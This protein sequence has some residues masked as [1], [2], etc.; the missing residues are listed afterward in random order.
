MKVT[1][2]EVS[3]IFKYAIF[4]IPAT[5][6]LII[7]N[8]TDPINLP[9][10]LALSI[11]AFI[12][13]VLLVALR[14]YTQTR[15]YE[16]IEGKALVSLYF[17][18]G[19]FMIIAGL[20]NNGNYIRA[21]FGTNGRN[22]GLIYYLTAILVSLILLCVVIKEL[23]INYLYRVLSFTSIIFALYCLLQYLDLDPIAWNNPYSR[24]IGTLGNPNFSASALA[25]FAIFWFYMLISNYSK[26]VNF[27][28]FST[29]MGISLSF[30]SWSTESLQG[31][32]VLL[33]GVAFLAFIA[34]RERF[35][36]RAIPYLFFIGGGIS[37]LFVFLSFLGIG[38]L[39]AQLE[40]YTLKLRGYYAYFA[41]LAMLDSPWS[42]VGVDNYITAFRKFRTQEFIQ[43]Y[44]VALNANNA[45]STPAQV[46]AT[47][48]VIVFSLY[49][50][51]HLWILIR[52]LK[53]INSRNAS[54]S[55]L[56]GIALIWILVFS[57]SI[58]SIEIIGLG[59]MNWLLGAILLNSSHSLRV[60][61]LAS[62]KVT[63]KKRE[64]RA[65]PVWVG[66]LTIASFAIGILP[67]IGISIEDR[68]LLNITTIRVENDESR[69][70]VRENFNKLSNRTLLES[71]QVIQ[72]VN[73]LSQAGLNKEV[74]EILLRLHELNPRDPYPVDLLSSYYSNSN[75]L[76][77]EI[78]FYIKFIEL[79]PLNYQME[80]LL[81]DAY[82][83][84]GD[85]GLLAKS[86]ERI[87]ALA[88]ESQEFLDA[89][90]LLEKLKT[91]PS[92]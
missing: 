53:I 66:S 43:Q 10:L 24:V 2:Q 84:K 8:F 15:R 91:E 59:V 57:Q 63:E 92:D 42:G 23:E 37:L 39:G 13:L 7:P 17:L 18:I 40:Q 70:W 54:K 28:I 33:V 90:A 32:V 56:K 16:S 49:C 4:S 86:V 61:A 68:A 20:S 50:L 88:P 83:R 41:I 69:D 78:K 75:Q 29:V 47:F 74:E 30:L 14:K 60:K 52:A 72:I 82:F 85:I 44:G 31:L 3:P 26:N 79:D 87:K 38:P 6:L 80:F 5:I 73:N 48:G 81:A 35:S 71:S 36:S 67:A 25:I 51:L 58:L 27:K 76:D 11:C 46:G 22:N 21:L 64:S 1:K 12:S 34:I 45:H 19:I 55:H 65:L 77:E 62:G 9:K 89:Q